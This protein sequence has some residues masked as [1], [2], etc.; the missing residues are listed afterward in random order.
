M[1][2]S[3][4]CRIQL[5]ADCLGVPYSAQ[6]IKHQSWKAVYSQHFQRLILHLV[7]H[8]ESVELYVTNAIKK[9]ADFDWIRSVGCSL[10][11][12]GKE[13]GI[14]NGVTW[15]SIPWCCKQKN[16][17]MNEAS[18]QKVIEMKFQILSHQ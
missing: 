10:H 5:W 18:R 12:Q 7:A 17:L 11:Y 1:C 15:I 4:L 16:Q 6:T 9:G 13:E 14:A 2:F 3:V 8:L